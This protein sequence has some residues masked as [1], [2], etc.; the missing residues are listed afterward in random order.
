VVDL[1][2]LQPVR[3]VDEYRLDLGELVDGDGARNPIKRSFPLQMKQL[4]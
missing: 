3:V 2:L 4:K 1:R